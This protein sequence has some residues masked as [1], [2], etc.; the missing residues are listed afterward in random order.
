M[1][2][3]IDKA[4]GVSGTPLNRDYMMALQGFDAIETVFNSD[5]SITET[6]SLGET[7]TT[8]F[9]SDGSITESFVGEKTITKTITFNSDGSISEVLSEVVS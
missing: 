2:E 3:F 8:T 9:N 6:N 7:K 5:G 1:R 4:D